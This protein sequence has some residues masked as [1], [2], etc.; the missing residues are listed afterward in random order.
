MAVG[1]LL[2]YMSN[3]CLVVNT[4]SFQVIYSKTLTFKV[5]KKKTKKGKVSLFYSWL[6]VL[7]Y[8]MND[9]KR[10]IMLYNSMADRPKAIQM[11]ELITMLAKE[12]S[13]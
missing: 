10:N 3:S 5:K 2:L 12:I 13:Y 6:G 8:C 4:T 7:Q 9:T 11:T 1:I